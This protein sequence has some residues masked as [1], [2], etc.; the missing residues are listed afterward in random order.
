MSRRELMKTTGKV[1]VASALAGL[2]LPQVHAGESNTINIA[3]VGCGNRGTG[4]AGDA[5]STTLGPTKL[6]A[7]ADVF[8]KKPGETLK[9]LPEFAN[10][11]DVPKE[12]QFDDFEAY[13]HALDCLKP[14]DVVILATPPAFRWVH[15]TYALQKGLHVFME[16]PVTVD[17]PSTRKMFQLADESEKRPDLKVGVGLMCR[18]CLVRK[19]MLKRIQDGAIG[20][21]T[22]LRAYRMAGKTA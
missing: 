3:L 8:P 5:L 12:R 7:V 18:H 13:K 21:I 9:N 10:E 22:L 2:A 4:A 20:D 11:I 19:E 15:F 16:K 1:A 14:G 17:G 6:V